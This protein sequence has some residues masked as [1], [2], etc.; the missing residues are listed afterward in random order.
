MLATCLKYYKVKDTP[1]DLHSDHKN[2]VK[3]KCNK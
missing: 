2:F 1:K 3:P